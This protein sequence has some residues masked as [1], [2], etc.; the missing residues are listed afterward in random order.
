ML[1]PQ[2]GGASS[3]NLVIVLRKYEVSQIIQV[4]RLLQRVQLGM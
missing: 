1:S 4:V 3:H 2:T